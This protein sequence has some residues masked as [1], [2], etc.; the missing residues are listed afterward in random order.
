MSENNLR[1]WSVDIPVPMAG[2]QETLPVGDKT[3]FLQ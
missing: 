3:N 1:M 2:S